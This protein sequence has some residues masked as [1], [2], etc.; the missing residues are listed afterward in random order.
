MRALRIKRGA[1]LALAATALAATAAVA[2]AGSAAAS[3]G[4]GCAGPTWK[5]VCIADHNNGTIGADAYLNLGNVN[6]NCYVEFGVFDKTT[7]DFATRQ[8]VSCQN[9]YQHLG[10][11]LS[12][13]ASGH[14]YV[15]FTKIHWS[16]G[17]DLET[18][19]S[20]VL[21]Y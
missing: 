11:V 1:A 14:Q 4:G 13:P 6:S 18:T 16:G 9:G 5:N 8:S 19:D 15:G 10:I 3:S 7:W 2:G 17:P 12:N 21:T 20:P